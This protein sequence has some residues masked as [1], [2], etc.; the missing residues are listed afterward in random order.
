MIFYT[1]EKND[2][3]EEKMDF[4]Q[5][6]YHD[7]RG[8]QMIRLRKSGEE[9]SQISTCDM[10]ELAATG[11]DSAHFYT[12]VNTFR[13][14]KRT[15]DRVYNYT[16]IYIDLDCH[17]NNPEEIRIAKENTV[18]ILEAAYESGVLTIPTM[19]TDTGRG[20]GLQYVLAN[21]IANIDQTSSQRAFF[22]KVRKGIF[23]KYQEV[24]SADVQDM[25]IAQVDSAV[26]DDA[27]VCRLPG[28]YNVAAGMY[29]RL[30]GVS[31]NYYEL[32]D[33]V[34]GCHLWTWKCEEEYRREKEEKAKK[35]H[36]RAKNGNII[37]FSEY[38]L[39]FLNARLDQLQ[40]LQE[41]RGADCTN[42][43][44]EQLLF[45]AY[46]TLVQIN[47]ETAAKRLQ[48]INEKF[49]DPLDQSEL[50]HIVEETDNSKGRDH[51]GYYKLK[52]EY[53]VERLGLSN[54][55]IKAIGLAEGWKRSVERSVARKE[56]QKKREKVIDLLQQEDSL[57]Y[58]QIA[59]ATGVSRRK[60]CS[61]AREEGL[62]RY[63]KAARRYENEDQETEQ[64]K[65]AE[66]IN[67]ETIRNVDSQVD[68]SAKNAIRSVCVS[69][70][71]EIGVL[72]ADSVGDDWYEWLV[73]RSAGSSEALELLSL[74]DWSSSFGG[75]GV[76]LEDFL[77]LHMPEIMLYPERISHLLH[78]VV[79][80]YI[81]EL[82]VVECLVGLGSNLT[83]FPLLYDYLRQYMGYM[84]VDD[85]GDKGI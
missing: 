4:I 85:S 13:G 8:G 16:S 20:F 80:M 66:I 29:C 27:R 38:L 73:E 69:F 65:K 53:L 56:K 54:E 35:R 58:E 64:E 79:E 21:S 18:R 40:K 52:N 14:W 42:D 41:L 6:L 10:D 63:K 26:L 44:R 82:G 7:K 17:S 30:I 78:M 84:T 5:H 37:S 15:A 70:S 22:K 67:I 39:P 1:Y 68:K 46:S 76:I 59:E 48:E 83:D 9:V 55:E 24:L 11:T 50:D 51:Q 71:A 49:T 60:V 19:I 3:E 32:S 36:E 72:A 57:S 75:F 31:G 28:T 12:T 62:M 47:S 34:K 74:Y 33:L 23:E 2:M 43:C 61:I 77:E 81:V 25:Q 45:I